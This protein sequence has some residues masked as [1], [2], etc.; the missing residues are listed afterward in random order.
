MNDIINATFYTIS[1]IKTTGGI[2]TQQD[3]YI[4]GIANINGSIICNNILSANSCTITSM[5]AI[6][7]TNSTNTTTGAFK[8]AGKLRILLS[9]NIEGNINV[10]SLLTVGTSVNFNATSEVTS[11]I[12]GPIKH[13]SDLSVGKLAFVGNYLNIKG[14]STN[15]VSKSTIY[16]I[17]SGSFYDHTILCD[18]TSGEF[19]ITLPSSASSTERLYVIKKIDSS[20]NTVTISKNSTETIKGSTSK[21]LSTQ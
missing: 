2:N 17:D 20:G 21:F 15:L 1:S 13:S 16:T 3:C 7:V 18:A 6:E 8:T 9:A 14:L 11:I 5:N 4:N 19:T 12:S 10:T